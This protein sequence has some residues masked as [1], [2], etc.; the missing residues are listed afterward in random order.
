MPILKAI[1]AAEESGLARETTLYAALNKN[2]EPHLFPTGSA[3]FRCFTTPSSA[4]ELNCGTADG[5]FEVASI[6]ECCLGTN[7]QFFEPR[8]GSEGCTP[9]IGM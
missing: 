8:A 7:G 1:G 5:E 3:Q 6:E 9:C 2:H 4:G